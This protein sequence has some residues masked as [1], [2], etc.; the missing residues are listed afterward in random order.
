[1]PT[2][3]LPFAH[4]N[5]RRNP[6]GEVTRAERAGLAVVDVREWV[7]HLAHPR[8]VIQFVGDHGRGKST[9]LIALA[10]ALPGAR[11]VRVALDE[12]LDLPEG[13][14]VV[15]DEAQKAPR[16]WLSRLFAGGRVVALASHGDHARELERA[17]YQVRTERVEG[18]E[19]DTLRAVCERRIDW[20]RRGEG[21]TPRV[22]EA[23]LRVLLARHRDDVRAIERDLYR[24]FQALEGPPDVV[25]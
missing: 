8:R 23:T 6:F 11:Y 20:V 4:L 25:V 2:L 7:A 3:A 16:R 24:C 14:V 21:P 12:H 1:M 22:G 9:R 15:L 5:L 13:G 17:G 19:L 18:L 10:A